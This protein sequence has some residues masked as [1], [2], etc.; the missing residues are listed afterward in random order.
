MR[1]IVKA[2]TMR[3]DAIYRD[4]TS[5]WIPCEGSI[6]A[7]AML[8]AGFLRTVQRQFPGILDVKCLGLARNDLSG[9]ST[10]EDA[11]EPVLTSVTAG[12]AGAR[13]VA[14]RGDKPWL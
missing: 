9:T 10:E 13:Y 5:G 3:K 6:L 11:F 2:I 7:D 4:I 8:A 1:F 12:L 14:R